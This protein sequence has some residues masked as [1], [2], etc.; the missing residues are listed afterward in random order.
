MILAIATGIKLLLVLIMIG[1]ISGLYAATLNLIGR[2][3]F[4]GDF[5]LAVVYIALC[6]LTVR[7]IW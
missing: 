1:V 6:L 4:W 3:S 2:S 5:G 7:T